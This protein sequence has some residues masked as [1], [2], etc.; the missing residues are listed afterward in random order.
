MGAQ[1]NILLEATTIALA[2]SAAGGVLAALG[3]EDYYSAG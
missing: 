3:W 2:M 1:A